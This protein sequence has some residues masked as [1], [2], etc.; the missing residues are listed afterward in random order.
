M[1]PT[2]GGKTE[3]YLGIIAFVIA[4]R[5]FTRGDKGKGTTVLMRYTLRMLTLQQFQRATML[6]LAL[7]VMR[8][9]SFQLPHNCSFGNERITIG[10]F[11]G[12]DSLPNKWDGSEKSMVQ[13]LKKISEAI[14]SNLQIETNIPFT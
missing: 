13:E 7:E 12:G 6:I 9:K 4:L 3:A 11:V 14:E 2:G 1:F 10:L 8:Q 5:R